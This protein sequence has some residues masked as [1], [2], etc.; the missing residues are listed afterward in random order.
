MQAPTCAR[1]PNEAGALMRATQFPNE[2]CLEFPVFL[3]HKQGVPIHRCF[4]LV[5]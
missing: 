3:R 4:P 5:T 2:Q 1:S